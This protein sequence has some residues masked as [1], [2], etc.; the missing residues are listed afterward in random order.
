[1][2]QIK[3]DQTKWNDLAKNSDPIGSI[4]SLMMRKKSVYHLFIAWFV[5]LVHSV[6]TIRAQWWSSRLFSRSSIWWENLRLFALI[7][8]DYL[9]LTCLN[10]SLLIKWFNLKYRMLLL[11]CT[12]V[13]HIFAA[14]YLILNNQFSSFHPLSLFDQLPMITSHFV[15]YVYDATALWYTCRT[16]WSSHW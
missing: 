10:S 14:Q 4:S 5:V 12:C 8:I 1:M 13:E 9:L 16:S 7:K 6:L 2:S 15:A 11:F 3:A